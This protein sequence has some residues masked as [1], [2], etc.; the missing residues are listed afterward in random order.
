VDTAHPGRIDEIEVLRVVAAAMVV[1]DHIPFNLFAWHSALGDV[2]GAYWNGSSGMDL[3]LAI[4]G[5]VVARALLPPLDECRDTLGRLTVVLGFVARRF[6]RLWPA[7][8]LWLAIPLLL[9][10]TFNSTDAFHGVRANL[11]SATAAVLMVHDLWFARVFGAGDT[12]ITYPYW[13][14]SLTEQL[15]LALPALALA[16]RGRL[17]W[18]LLA[19]LAWQFAL[20]HMAVF[21]STR[22][23]D[24]ALGA[25]LAIWSR[26]PGY[27]LAT[28]H[29]L[30]GRAAWR[31]V[32]L[33]AMVA[34]LGAL[35]SELPRPMISV[36]FGL[37]AV[38]CGVLVY[39][40][41]LDL[42]C[43]VKQGWPRRALAWAG[44]RAYAVT[45][46]H[47]PAFAL[48]REL[49]AQLRGPIYVVTT[50]LAAHFLVTG[51]ALTLVLAELTWRFVE[52]PAR[53]HGRALALRPGTA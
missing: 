27:G 32:F 18:G 38:L 12:G 29:F 52:A 11:A 22:P 17:V 39:V 20:P 13:A 14:L 53:R 25:L 49:Y 4:S 50:Q 2:L 44:G 6:W 51:I 26:Q 31:L 28:P 15:S 5:F 23:G 35:Q 24:F 41:S 37:S 45:L 34:L 16:L 30:R 21:Y 47:L 9:S 36:P 7:A 48:T 33:A 10:A 42:G 46:V 19:L 3:F 8:W 43:L 1:V 40:A